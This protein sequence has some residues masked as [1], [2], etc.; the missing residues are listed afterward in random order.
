MWKAGCAIKCPFKCSGLNTGL[1]LRLLLSILSSYGCFFGYAS[2]RLW[3]V[4]DYS[5]VTLIGKIRGLDTAD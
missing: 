3:L 5:T 4:E 1:F 2:F